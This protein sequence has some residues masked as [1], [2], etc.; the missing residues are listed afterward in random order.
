M[1]TYIRRNIIISLPVEGDGECVKIL[2]IEAGSLTE[3]VESFLEATKGYIVPAGSVVVLTSVSRLAGVG[4]AQYI[5]EFV[6]SRNRLL[7]A[8]QDG[9]LV[10]HGF[11]IP[12]FG[13]SD[14]A[15]IRALTD[16]VGWL[17]QV[18]V[19]NNRDVV[20]TRNLFKKLVLEA[21]S[22]E[23]P[24]N[25]G[26]S[27]TPVSSDTGSHAAPDEFRFEL[28][29]KLEGKTKGI[30]LSAPAF[31]PDKIE[32]L[33]EA[34]ESELLN[35]LILELNTKFMTD[36]APLTS[37]HGYT[38][39]DENPA[40]NLRY[41]IIGGSHAS[42][43]ADCMD[44]QDIKVVDL[45][46]PGWL[47]TEKSIDK[48]V[49]DLVKVLEEDTE[50]ETV[51]IYHLFDNNVYFSVQP[52]GTMA[53]PVKRDGKYHVIGDLGMADRTIIKAL[54]S[55]ASPLLRAGGENKK[56]LFSP[57]LRYAT[58]ACCSNKAH[59][60]NLRTA[61]QGERLADIAKWLKDI[62]FFKRIRNFRIL[63]PLKHLLQEDKFTAAAKRITRYWGSDPVHMS[64][65]GYQLLAS[66]AAKLATED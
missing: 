12:L 65:E 21:G 30:F 41:I 11:P 24:A 42:R 27:E 20:A 44:D 50:L 19:H 32:P 61:G 4:A 5:N 29:N 59:V 56:I 1:L 23:A 43:L 28:P 14:K 38:S 37:E 53:L 60:T 66:A 25:T 33:S 62:A 16:T 8:F 31:V 22:P 15:C 26:S 51:I 10:V 58:G 13:I 40:A 64:R 39:H 2:R 57:L 3:L 34:V 17:T 18:S 9:L 7:G 45:T 55:T 46:M 48:A 54:F 35:E 49:T 36:L 47:I 6:S 63:D 52:D